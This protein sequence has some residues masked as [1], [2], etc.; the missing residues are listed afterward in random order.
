MKL[1]IPKL[2]HFSDCHF[3]FFN[4]RESD[5]E[6]AKENFIAE[7]SKEVFDKEIQPF[8]DKGI[9]SIFEA[10]PNDHSRWFVYEVSKLSDKGRI[11]N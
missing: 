3:A 4:Q 5:F 10:K 8:V 2:K 7:F 6:N 1:E 9:M 11:N